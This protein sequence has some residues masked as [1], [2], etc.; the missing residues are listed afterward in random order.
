VDGWRYA[1]VGDAD[2]AALCGRVIWIFGKLED[3]LTDDPQVLAKAIASV[4]AEPEEKG[5]TLNGLRARLEAAGLKVVGGVEV[6]LPDVDAI[7]TALEALSGLPGGSRS[8]PPSS[9]WRTSTSARLRY[10][11]RP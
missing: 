7:G 10:P 11:A 5:I 2:L 6:T 1:T 9:A 8:R 3:G 4:L